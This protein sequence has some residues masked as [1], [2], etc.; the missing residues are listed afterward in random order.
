[1]N[2]RDVIENNK[3]IAEFMG[4]KVAN[5]DH[6]EYNKDGSVKYTPN[7]DGSKWIIEIWT[8]PQG[9]NDEM[10]KRWGWGDY[11]MG[12]WYYNTSYE[13]L[14]P[15]VEKIIKFKYEDDDTAYLRTFGMM[16]E[17]K[18]MVR[19]NRHQLFSS[20]TLVEATWLAVVDFIRCYNEQNK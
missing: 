1:M 2:A 16:K 8:R 18:I 9:I 13:W 15:V 19:F 12:K 7:E 20:D 11:T 17:G 3:L 6:T 14:M 5:E 10:Y 4:A